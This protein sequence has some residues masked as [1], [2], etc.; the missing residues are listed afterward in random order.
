MLSKAPADYTSKWALQCP[1]ETFLSL[2]C[3]D[4][5]AQGLFLGGI[6]CIRDYA[7]RRSKLCFMRVDTSMNLEMVEA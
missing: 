4:S 5:V 7:V 6:R 2:Q 3:H 1:D